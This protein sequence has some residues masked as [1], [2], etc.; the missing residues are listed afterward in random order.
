MI[1]RVCYTS[2]AEMQRAVQ[3]ADGVDQDSAADRAIETAA[4]NI[5]AQ[6]HRR[7]YPNDATRYFDWPNQGGSGGGQYADPWRL[8]LDQYDVVVLT[9][10][11]TGSV[12][13]PLNQVFLEPVNREEWEPAEYL[14]LDRSSTAAFGSGPSPQHNIA[15]TGTFG[16][17][18]D[19]DQVAT[20]AADVGSSDL[21]VT[22]SDGSQAGPGNLLVLG[23]GRGDA[24]YPT[25]YGYA[26][27]LQPY[28]GERVLI[29][30]VAFADTGLAQS[31]SGCST[32]STSDQALSTTGAG[33]LNKGEVILL[34]QEQMLVEQVIAGVATVTRAFHGTTLYEHS[35]SEIYALRQ[36]SVLRA[37]LGTTASTYDSA[38]AVY[39]HRIP[40]LVRD[41]SI[42]EATNQVLQEGT[43]YAR[44]VG[45]GDAAYPAPGQ[46]LASKWDEAMTAHGRKARQRAV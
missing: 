23:Y 39:K 40:P 17:S 27:A 5:D 31:G 32:A 26:G 2:R 29:T 3:F 7:F 28:E 41:L 34:D 18:A 13:I 25:A 22:V 12:T 46:D 38:A 19:A 4:D 42:G 44:T 35:S 11:V 20:L 15:L 33:A 45:T 37:Q 43:G 16:Y 9:S 30:D 14:E 24:P 6:L 8:W 10:L 36:Y 1:S 21:T